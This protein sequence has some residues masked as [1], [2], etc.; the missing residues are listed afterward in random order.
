MIQNNYNLDG[1]PLDPKDGAHTVQFDHCVRT[2]TV[3]VR[4][5]RPL[6]SS[7]LRDHIQTKFEVVSLGAVQ[8][9]HYYR[10]CSG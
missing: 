7:E 3:Q 10:K 1:S 6:S 5:M 8:S 2:F 4:T 9:D